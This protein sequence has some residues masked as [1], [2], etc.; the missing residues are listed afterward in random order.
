MGELQAVE[1]PGLPGVV[2]AGAGAAVPW[3][4]EA[5]ARLPEGPADTDPFWR[6]AAAFLVG[7]P[8]STAKAYLDD[9]TAWASECESNRV[10]PFAAR[11]HHVSGR[12]PECRNTRYRGRGSSSLSPRR[13]AGA[14]PPAAGTSDSK[15]C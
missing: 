14:A 13:W 10:H 5:L 12:C 15:P 8:D 6:L 2:A 7:Y 3:R 4:T 1:V 11:R 9:L